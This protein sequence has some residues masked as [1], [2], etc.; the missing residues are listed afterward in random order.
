MATIHNTKTR[1]APKSYAITGAVGRLAQ[2]AWT[3][4]QRISELEEQLSPLKDR[5]ALHFVKTRITVINA[6]PAQ[7]QYKKRNNWTYSVKLQNLMLKVQQMQK[8]EQENGTA[9]NDP[10]YSVAI[11]TAKT[12]AKK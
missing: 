8:M 6:G 1:T 3:I 10:T 12:G 5:L 9:T 2:Q 7:I 11:A 4:K